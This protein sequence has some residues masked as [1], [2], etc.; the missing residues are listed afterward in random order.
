MVPS[1]PLRCRIAQN[2]T[3]WRGDGLA[4]VGA[5]LVALA[6]LGPR[7]PLLLEGVWGP[8][9]PWTHFDF[10]GG[11]WLWWSAAHPGDELQLQCAPD[12]LLPLRHHFPNPF[13]AWLLGPLAFREGQVTDRAWQIWNLSQLAHHVANVCGAALLARSLGARVPGAVAA[14][15]LVAS[16]P[17]MLHEI[18]GG[19]TLPGAVWPG[20][21]GLAVLLR[22]A[23]GWAGL[24][25]GLQSLFYLYTGALVGLVAVVL[26]PS[27]RLSTVI[28]LA[29]PYLA[30]LQ[31]V[32]ARLQG[33]PP[34]AGYTA[35]PLA[36]VLGLDSVPERFRLHPLLVLLGVG[37]LVRRRSTRLLASAAL[38]ALVAL[39][40]TPS[41][42][43]DGPLFVSPL[44]W[45]MWSIP[46]LSRLHHPVRAA[47]VLV[48]ILAAGWGAAAGHRS[49][50]PA[51]RGLLLA[52]SLVLA[53]GNAK[54][55]HLAPS[56]ASSVRP[57]GAAAAH[58]LSTQ[59]GSVVDL[60]GAGGAA[61]GL[62][63]LHGR[64]MLEGVRR[65][66]PKGRCGSLR[67]RA[68]GWLAGHRQP[69]LAEALA[70]VGYRHVLAIERREALTA[71]A[72]AALEADLGAPVQP[73][74]Y[75]IPR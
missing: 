39:G 22:G 3:S 16:S 73:G 68:D 64:P 58:F 25:I 43:L 12:G 51:A 4:L 41:L 69:G 17:V 55:V 45:A 65:A 50:R 11:W 60:T 48:P 7:L 19:R 32:A 56:W 62:Q 53:V 36:G 21:I 29:V 15:A 47:L 54:A 49:L 72:R 31:P 34:P 46:G 59:T 13:D 38:V 24:W 23:P 10:L 14:A 2:E 1:E 74:V 26:R 44:A 75:E 5:V 35:L 8:E 28:L 57:A 66:G 6:V 61:L 40:P 37:G 52:L 9:H 33:S 71:A 70:A 63:P 18:A 20:L 67:Q 27:P 30:W 42:S